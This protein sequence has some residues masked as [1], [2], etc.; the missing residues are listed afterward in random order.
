MLA[1]WGNNC[2]G[3]IVNDLD[4]LLMLGYQFVTGYLL[5]ILNLTKCEPK[6]KCPQTIIYKPEQGN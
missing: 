4:R 1:L 3:I 6:T 5:T 2:S